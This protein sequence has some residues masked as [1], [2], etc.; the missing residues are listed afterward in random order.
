MKKLAIMGTALA[1]A[2]G[3]AYAADKTDK[4][5]KSDRNVIEKQQ[6]KG[7]AL[8]NDTSFRVL[9]K[10]NDGYLSK[11]E[12]A[13][14]ADLAKRFKEADGN[15]DGKLSRM[16]YLKEMAKIDTHNT[17]NKVS[18]STDKDRSSAT[19]GSKEK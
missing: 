13:G 1:L 9:D 18:R 11:A 8:N 17:A 5:A 15:N 12:A 2:V 6:E 16:E 3:T 14:N 19:G 10:N 7:G 4:N